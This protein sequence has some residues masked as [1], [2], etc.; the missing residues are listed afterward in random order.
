MFIKSS[1]SSGFL[2]SLVGVYKPSD[3]VLSGVDFHPK[4]VC[5]Q[6]NYM[7]PLRQP[8]P[9]R[10]TSTFP[11][12]LQSVLLRGL[13]NLLQLLTAIWCLLKSPSTQINRPH[14]TMPKES[15]RSCPQ[16][17]S[18]RQADLDMPKSITP[19]LSIVPSKQ[20]NESTST[21]PSPVRVLGIS[22]SSSGLTNHERKIKSPAPKTAEEIRPRRILKSEAEK[23]PP[24]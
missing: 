17:I 22:E 20:D 11:K 10:F 14:K 18:L 19:P 13:Y 7:H 6:D 8:L 21:S 24:Q 2:K 1:P 16:D 5:D 3:P 4:F 15:S 9:A 12:T 23:S